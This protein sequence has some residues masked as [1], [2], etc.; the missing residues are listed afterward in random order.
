MVVVRTC[1][2]FNI[3]GILAAYLNVQKTKP[4]VMAPNI[5]TLKVT[6]AERHG[7]TH[8]QN[9]SKSLQ[10]FW[11]GASS[12]SDT[13]CWGGRG[14]ATHRG[15]LRHGLALASSLGR[16]LN[17]HEELLCIPILLK[18]WLTHWVGGYPQNIL[19]HL[20]QYKTFSVSSAWN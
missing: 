19:S 15:S 9:G 10:Y 4:Q 16:K 6:E 18:P 14:G 5:H 7:K 8:T 1:L 13:G 20:L 11:P 3:Y 2:Q 12:L 17:S